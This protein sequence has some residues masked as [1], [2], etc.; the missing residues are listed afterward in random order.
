MDRPKK[1]R[2]E[3]KFDERS[4]APDYGEVFTANSLLES[5][6][7]SMEDLIRIFESLNVWET[8]KKK[9][10]IHPDRGDRI[11]IPD[12]GRAL[13]DPPKDIPYWVI[14]NPFVSEIHYYVI[15]GGR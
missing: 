11:I 12:F 8:L 2:V 10:D 13:F 1:Y 6:S 7:F 5:P 14:Q 15:K 3:F 4:V 9:H